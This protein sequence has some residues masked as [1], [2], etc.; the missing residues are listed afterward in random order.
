MVNYRSG[1]T[2]DYVISRLLY[3][4]DTGVFTWLPISG[5]W[6]SRWNKR[7]AGTVAGAIRDNGYRTINIQNKSYLAHRIAWL[8]TTGEWPSA[9]IDHINRN[10]EDNRRSNL[11]LATHAENMRNGTKLNTNKSGYVGVSLRRTA[12]VL[13]WRA[14]IGID[15]KNKCLGSYATP[16]E[17]AAAYRAAKPI[18]HGEF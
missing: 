17:A 11:R 12:K 13:K 7:Y 9:E 1:V 2:L 18:Y 5:K 14:L 8:M 10:R 4:A 3:D 6:S 16:E 15:G